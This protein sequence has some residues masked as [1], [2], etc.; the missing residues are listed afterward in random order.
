[1]SCLDLSIEKNRYKLT[2]AF[3]CTTNVEREGMVTRDLNCVTSF[4]F[5]F[6]IFTIQDLYCVK[7]FK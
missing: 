1:M 3:N 7:C 4:C 5:Q 6:R 2:Y